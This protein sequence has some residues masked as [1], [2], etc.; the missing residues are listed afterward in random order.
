MTKQTIVYLLD[1]SVKSRT[2]CVLFAAGNILLHIVET[3]QTFFG[4]TWIHRIK[5]LHAIKKDVKGL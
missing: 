3:Q 4:Y 2:A 5:I 1:Y